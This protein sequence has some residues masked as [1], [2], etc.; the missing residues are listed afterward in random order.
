MQFTGAPVEM[1]T[2]PTAREASVA[3]SFALNE[4]V[5]GYR[6]WPPSSAGP[7]SRGWPPPPASGWTSERH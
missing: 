6:A 1:L 5:L 2:I 7:G 3:A 4:P